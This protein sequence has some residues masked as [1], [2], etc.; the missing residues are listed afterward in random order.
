MTTA[1]WDAFNSNNFSLAISNASA[2]IALFEAGASNK[3]GMVQGAVR[4]STTNTP[5]EGI[6]KNEEEKQRTLALGPLNSV[7]TCWFI[8]GDSYLQIAKA[9]PN[10]LDLE[11]LR[12]SRDAFKATLEFSHG[13]CWDTNGFFWSPARTA[14]EER[15][16]GIEQQ[17]STARANTSGK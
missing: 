13:R 6:P 14:R 3:Q 7:S 10:H 15:L 12:K 2:C 8:E 5:T 17:L 9:D 1:A 16:P 4:I 11:A